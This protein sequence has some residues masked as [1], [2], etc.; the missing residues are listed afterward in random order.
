M[1]QKALQAWRREIVHF[2]AGEFDF[3]VDE[4]QP[5]HLRIWLNKMRSLDYFPKTGKATYTGTNQFFIIPD[6]EAWLNKTFK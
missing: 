1:D 2:K 4:I 5:W 3:N 6:I